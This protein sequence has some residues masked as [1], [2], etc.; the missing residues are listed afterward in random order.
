M[1][2]Y[3]SKLSRFLGRTN[4]LFNALGVATNHAQF[5]V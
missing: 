5:H 4:L 1:M 3:T 2:L